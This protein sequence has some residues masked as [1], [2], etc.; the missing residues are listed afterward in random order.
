VNVL[1]QEVDP[2][3]KRS[4]STEGHWSWRLT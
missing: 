1:G 3:W 4:C 2:G